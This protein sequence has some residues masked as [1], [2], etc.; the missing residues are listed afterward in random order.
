MVLTLKTN[1]EGHPLILGWL[2]LAMIDVFIS[3]RYGDMT[4][5]NGNFIGNYFPLIK[6]IASFESKICRNL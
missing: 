4:I 3:Y 5:S 1:L 2:W 6:K